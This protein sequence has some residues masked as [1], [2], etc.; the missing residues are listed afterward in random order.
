MIHT[1]VFPGDSPE[2]PW[3]RLENDRV[4]AEGRSLDSLPPLD[5]ALE[6]EVVAVVPG[7][8]VVLHWVELPALAPAQALAAARM[9]AA[10]VSTTPPE[11]THVAMG[12]RGADAMA[13]L[14]LVGKQHMLGWLAT[15][16]A[17]GID[18]D[19]MVPAPL[20]LP[21]P[22]T[23]AGVTVAEAD[24]QWLVRG[25]HLAFA[26]EPALAGIMV[27]DEPIHRLADA[28]WHAG[29]TL[30]LATMPI[31]LR[32]GEFTRVRRLPID[33]R[34]VRRIALLALGLLALLLGT[35]FAA[36]LRLTLAA[37][38]AEMQLADAARSV[39]PRGT[40]V[41]NPRAQVA[42]R[43]ADLGGNGPAFASLAAPLLVAIQGHPDIMLNSLS[44]A[45][46]TGLVAGLVGASPPDL[47][48]IVAAMQ[49]AGLDAAT[50]NPRDDGGRQLVDLTVRPR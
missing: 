34:Q 7:D 49:A 40:I 5:P 50:G 9:L 24:G 33:R 25:P 38:H 11:S 1:L 42:A 2:T 17:Q 28:D 37:D 20:L 43:L 32:Q 47:D 31:D 44:Y 12:K 48:A 15:L 27:G 10:D 39:L 13:P 6:S 21:L 29:L 46:Q 8:C 4:V 22:L 35:Q 16:A 23:E 41:T 45:P 30:T 14:A 19:R 26:A 18:P 36:L 3:L